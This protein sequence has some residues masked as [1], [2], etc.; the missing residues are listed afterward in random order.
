MK[1]EFGF[2]YNF[3]KETLKEFKK[4]IQLLKKTGDYVN[5]IDLLVSGDTGEENF[6]D[7]IK[8]IK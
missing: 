7:N 1:D 2:S 8:K 4:T 6:G 5:E 3:S